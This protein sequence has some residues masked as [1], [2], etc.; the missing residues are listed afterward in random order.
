MQWSGL[1]G[2]PCAVV[3]YN[4]EGDAY[5]NHPAS[6][7]TTVADIISCGFSQD[8]R[9]KRQTDPVSVINPLP[10]D[11]DQTEQDCLNSYNRDISVFRIN[12]TELSNLVSDFPCPPTLKQ[13]RADSGRFRL[14]TQSPLC[15]VSA[16]PQTSGTL[17]V[18][19]GEVH[20]AQQCCYENGYFCVDNSP[21]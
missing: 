12:A 9:R 11:P 4:S 6:G 1:S 16:T 19:L 14:H 15:Y 8:G 3:G 5:Q 21:I 10:S 20:A 2:A 13:V 18:V 7:F 17:S